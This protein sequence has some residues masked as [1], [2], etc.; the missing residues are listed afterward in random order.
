MDCQSNRDRA[1]LM[2][3]S[4]WKTFQHSPEPAAEFARRIAAIGDSQGVAAAA[5]AIA[6]DCRRRGLEMSQ[7]RALKGLSWAMERYREDLKKLD[8]VDDLTVE[9]MSR[10][11]F[12]GISG[13]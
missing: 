1:Y 3:L 8:K 9:A 6:E 4:C 7:A 10:D 2:A 5:E 13:L 11:R 12:P